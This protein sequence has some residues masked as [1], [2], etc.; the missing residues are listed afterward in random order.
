MRDVGS[1]QNPPVPSVAD[2]SPG[3]DRFSVFGREATECMGYARLL[4]R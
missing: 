3:R 2:Y 4:G 1:L